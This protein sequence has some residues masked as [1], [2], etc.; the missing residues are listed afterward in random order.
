MQNLSTGTRDGSAG[1]S[2]GPENVRHWVETAFVEGVASSDPLD[3]EPTASH[4][5]ESLD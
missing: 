4:Q 2:L 3:G 1:S 5:A